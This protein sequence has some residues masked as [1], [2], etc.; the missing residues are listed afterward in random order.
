MLNQTDEPL[1]AKYQCYGMVEAGNS[2]HILAQAKF[3][4]HETSVRVT[5]GTPPSPQPYIQ[6]AETQQLQA[7]QNYYLA[8]CGEQVFVHGKHVMACAA[9]LQ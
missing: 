2:V 9:I 7:Q 6:A 1:Q 8:W 4:A 5:D 3:V